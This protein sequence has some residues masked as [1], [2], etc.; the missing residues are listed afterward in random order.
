MVVNK[1]L[2]EIGITEYHSGRAPVPAPPNASRE[3]RLGAPVG[4]FRLRAL[5]LQSGD[6]PSAGSGQERSPLHQE[7]KPMS[8]EISSVSTSAADSPA[9]VGRASGPAQLPS[10]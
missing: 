10:N 3:S 7:G 1:L 6:L 2:R 5:A 4:L 8:S 9:L